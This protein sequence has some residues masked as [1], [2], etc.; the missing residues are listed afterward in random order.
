MKILHVSFSESG[1]A[2]VVARTLSEEQSRMGLDSSFE[3]VTKTSLRVSPFRHPV[4]TGLAALDMGVIANG[5]ASTLLSFCRSKTQLL[6][7]ADFSDIDVLHV[8]WMEGVLNHRAI[9]RLLNSGK[10]IVWSLHDMAPFT[11]GCHQS[12]GCE[13]FL[14]NCSSCPLARPAFRPMI[15]RL[16]Q[17]RN[18]F[19]EPYENFTIV[20]PSEWLAEKAR[21][22][23]IFKHQKVDV[24]QNPILPIFFNQPKNVSLV[25][26]PQFEDK[27]ALRLILVA[28]D[29][30]D[31]N[32]RVMEAVNA[33][34][35]VSNSY[36]SEISLKLVGRGGARFQK[37]S[38]V[39]WVG[40]QETYDLITHYDSCDILLS[41]SDAESFGLTVVEAASR[42]L[43]SITLKNRGTENLVVEGLTG[44]KLNAIDEATGLLERLA[45]SRKSEIAVMGAAAR[46]RTFSE[47][48]PANV[49]AKYQAAYQ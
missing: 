44:W 47:N 43:P 8:H 36:N 3:F 25:S 16:H 37:Y 34:A 5:R 49:A 39:H 40:G 21:A 26:P 9:Q 27:G 35:K 22:S 1:G 46:A 38:F 41:F 6:S 15:S 23:T 20:A 4:L 45:M 13:G 17:D 42:G 18:V 48:T 31:P 11:A 32:K 14:A 28:N 19:S 7:Q 10:R 24:I 29:L 2:G 12:L 33:V 30:D